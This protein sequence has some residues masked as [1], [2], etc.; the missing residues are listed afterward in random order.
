MNNFD[1]FFA[2]FGTIKDAELLQNVYKVID[3]HVIMDKN[4]PIALYYSILRILNIPEDEKYKY[5][6]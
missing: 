6:T 3:P 4:D 2:L 5:G 1:K